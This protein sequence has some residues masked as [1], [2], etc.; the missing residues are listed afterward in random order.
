M[1]RVLLF[2]VTLVAATL[3]VAPAAADPP[4]SGYTLY[5]NDDFNGTAPDTS[6]WNYRTDVKQGS[7]QL[8]GN[9]SVGNGIMT[10]ALKAESPPVSGKNWSGGGLVSKRAFRYGYYE[11]RAKMP[12]VAGWHTSF[13]LQAGNGTTTFPPEQR[14]EID[15]LE[16]DSVN[17]RTI[18]NGVITWQGNGVHAPFVVGN[19]Y[20]SGL[21]VRQWHTY[22]ADWSETSVKYYVDGQ[23]RYTVAY[24]PNQW[25]HD[26]VN[27]WLTS[28]AVP[29]GTGADVA[30]FDYVR[31]WQ[32]DYYVDN[33]GPAAYGYSE[34]GTWHDSTLDGWNYTSPSRYATCDTTGNAAVWRPP[35]RAAGNYQVSVWKIVSGNS[36][37]NARYDVGYNGGTA[38]QHVDG[39]A[40]T[41][42]WVSLGTYAFAAG[43]GGYV[44]VTGSGTGCARADA[45]KFIRV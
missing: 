43:Q 15:V 4:T 11:T 29:E 45:V 6:V 16:Q 13:W 20:D 3:T 44:K 18:H 17:Q 26:Y 36:D 33:D 30:Q 25:T 39:T 21:D 19:T 27:V 8:P 28:I 10:V 23:L 37:P 31:Y 38:T 34:S 5:F 35:L 22:G 9:V 41:S 7:A 40:G 32:K 12:A 2:A 24:N 14:T 42:G 1:R